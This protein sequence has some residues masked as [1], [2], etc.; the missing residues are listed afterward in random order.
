MRPSSPSNSSPTSN[1][2]SYKVTVLDVSQAQYSSGERIPMDILIRLV[3]ANT[4]ATHDFEAA[5][6]AAAITICNQF[7]ENK[8]HNP[9]LVRLSRHVSGQQSNI[10]HI[11]KNE[12]LRIPAG[13]TAEDLATIRQGNGILFFRAY[14]ES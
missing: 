13:T 1:L 12:V 11:P 5:D 8:G 6:D 2:N 10:F 3:N 7:C 14:P 9:Y 4:V